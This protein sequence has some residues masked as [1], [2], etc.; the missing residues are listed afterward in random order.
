MKKYFFIP[1]LLICIFLMAGCDRPKNEEQ[2]L[3][4]L[5]EYANAIDYD[6]KDPAKIYPYLCQEVRDGLTEDEFVECWAKERTYPYLT[7]LYIYDPVV[8]LAEDGM[9]GTAVYTQA[10]RIDGMTYEI[11]FVYE[12]GDYYVC[13]WYNFADGSY[14]D[15]FDTVVQSIDWYFDPDAINN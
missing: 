9:S 15:K 7:P 3:K 1:V 6:Y 14:L 13:D 4:R 12:N 10:A 5:N 8:S 11:D 2:A